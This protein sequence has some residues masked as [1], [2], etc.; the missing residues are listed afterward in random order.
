MARS[1][2]ASC[3]L[4]MEFLCLLETGQMLTAQTIKVSLV[5]GRQVFRV[6]C[7]LGDTTAVS[8]TVGRRVVMGSGLPTSGFPETTSSQQ[9]K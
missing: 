9:G 1:L 8:L 4:A 5:S 6:P 2:L 7:Q 3:R